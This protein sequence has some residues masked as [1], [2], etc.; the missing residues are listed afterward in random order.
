MFSSKK[1]YYLASIILIV[2][3]L[4]YFVACLQQPY[5]GLDLQ[6]VNGE[7]FVTISDNHG[8]GYM[9]GIRAGDQIL[10]INGEEPDNYNIVK[11]WH[12]L[13]GASTIEFHRLGQP[14]CQKITIE[15]KIDLLTVLSETPIVI[16]GFIFWFLGFITWFKR[17]FLKQTS[18]LFW[19]NWLFGLAIVLAQASS[20]G[21]PLAKE[22]EYISFSAAPVFLILFFS[23]FPLNN[24]NKL[25]IFGRRVTT[26][27]FLLVLILTIFNSLGYIRVT[28]VPSK[29]AIINMLIGIIISVCNL[30][31]LVKM[32]KDQP[33]RNEAGIILLGMVVG[34]LPSIL[35]TAAPIFF[36]SQ[37]QVNTRIVDIFVCAIPISLYYVIVNKYLPDSR[38]L[39]ETV[40]TYFFAGIIVSIVTLYILHFIN[41]VKVINA[42]AYLTV[43]FFT[44]L[45]IACFHV[46]RLFI[47]LL[48]RKCGLFR[49]QQQ[50]LKQRIVELNNSISSL[51]AED[52]IFEEAVRKLGI[53]GAFIIVENAQTGC[54]KRAVG[55]FRDNHNEQGQLIEYFHKNQR[56]DLEARILSDDFPAEIYVPFVSQD[57]YCGIFFGHRY[58]RIKFEQGELHFITLLAGQLAYQLLTMQ[59]MKELTKE[60]NSLSENSWN[61]Q[62]RNLR[63]QRITDAMSRKLEQERK[64]LTKEIADGPWQACLDLNRR[65]KYLEK[66]QYGGN[67]LQ[68]LSQMRELTEDLKYELRMIIQDLRPPILDDLGLIPAVELLCKDLM[69]KELTLITLEKKGINR[70]RRF[71]EE[72][73]LT[74]Y[75]FI[76]KGIMNSIKHSGSRK[77]KVQ[78]ELS[79]NRLELTVTDSGRG[80]DTNQLENW[81]ITGDHFGLGILKERLERLGGQLLIK[82]GI[83]QGTTL[84]A[85]LPVD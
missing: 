4:V 12:R 22:L 79:G 43:F 7:W 29:L 15:K 67:T 62:N 26:L 66:G 13:E 69:S 84:K 78:I 3:G 36:N 70:D 2:L 57:S 64:R 10:K 31:L 53:D 81:L 42:E 75:R 27:I 33:E 56:I 11:T 25:N 71:R 32:P 61:W 74:A 18:T 19:M 54:L 82:S 48:L 28:H 49:V 72:V 14:I 52:S 8:Q 58:S 73:E 38:R 34:F 30:S 46:M 44:L 24:Q 37:L 50:G 65:L 59:I 16:L 6:K 21:L 83:C 17:P 41:I 85:T 9:S 63:L 1:T 39:Y 80:F 47:R 45:F 35:F 68:A 23:I 60:I 77:Q 5:I 55:R 76:Q 20:R 51:F 40:I